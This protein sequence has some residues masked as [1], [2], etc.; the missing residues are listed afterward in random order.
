MADIGFEISGTNI[1]TR[2]IR[3]DNDFQ[4]NMT[5]AV[6][7]AKF[8]DGYEQR[9]R[10]GINNIEQTFYLKMVFVVQD[11]LNLYFYQILTHQINKFHLSIFDFPVVMILDQENF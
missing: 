5:P 9:G 4:R 8:G 2:T 10:K 6:K 1:A 11:H 3:P 7:V